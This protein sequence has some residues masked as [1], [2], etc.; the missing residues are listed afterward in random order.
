[1]GF[2]IALICKLPDSHLLNFIV[3]YLDLF[4]EVVWFHCFM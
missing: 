1:M 2:E 4:L 3:Q